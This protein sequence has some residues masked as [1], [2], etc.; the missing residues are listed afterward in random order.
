MQDR[1]TA[2]RPAAVK[3]RMA[4][5]F[6]EGH[7]KE[8]E[9]VAWLSSQAVEQDFEDRKVT[10]AEETGRPIDDEY[11]EAAARKLAETDVPDERI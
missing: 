2:P 7:A 11:V 1:T 3:L 5:A 9:V 8:P 10:L 4:A 6:L